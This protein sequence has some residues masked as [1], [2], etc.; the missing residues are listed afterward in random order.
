VKAVA[1]LTG[2]ALGAL[3]GWFLPSW[4]IPNPHEFEFLAVL[5]LRT[6]LAPAGAL[7]G[8]VVGLLVWRA[9]PQPQP[10]PGRTHDRRQEP[11]R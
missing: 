3:V 10:P 4:F 6:L 11:T 2:A 7:A 1:G 9:L 8:L 5:V